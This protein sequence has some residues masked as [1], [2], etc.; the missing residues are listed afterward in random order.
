VQTD[1]DGLKDVRIKNG[2]ASVVQLADPTPADETLAFLPDDACVEEVDWLKLVGSC[3]GFSVLFTEPV[4]IGL[5]DGTEHKGDRLVIGRA[6]PTKGLVDP[7]HRFAVR[8]AGLPELRATGGALQA[9]GL[10]MAP[11]GDA[12]LQAAPGSLTLSDLGDH[13]EAG[14][15][16]DLKQADSFYLDL[17]PI[18]LAGAVPMGASL[19]AQVRGSVDGVPNRSLGE[20]TITKTNEGDTAYAVI[21]DFTDIASPTHTVQVLEYHRL[22]AE[23]TGHTGIAALASSWPRR[24][25]KLDNELECYVGGFPNDTL[26]DLDG[27]LYRG[28]ELRVL[29]ETDGP[30][31]DF[32]SEFNLTAAGLPE[33]TLTR[34]AAGREG[35]CEPGPTRLCLK[36]GRFAVEVDWFTP[37]GLR[38]VGQAFP[39]T[40]DTGTFWFFGE[41]N[42]E[43]V[44]K[45]LDGCSVNGRFWVFA[46]GLTNVETL[47]TV[48][49]TRSGIA[50][51]YLNLQ[52]AAFLPVQDTAAFATCPAGEAAASAGVEPAAT[53]AP[54][55]TPEIEELVGR[56]RTAA[57]DAAGG[58]TA[59]DGTPLMLNG[60]R[61]RVEARWRTARGQTGAGTGVPLTDDSGYIWFFDDDNVEVVVK[62]LDACFVNGRFW[63]FAAGL[64]HVEV[65]LVVTDTATSVART[66]RNPLNTPF[67]PIQDTR[68]FATCE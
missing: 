10:L 5:S 53:A 56:A 57:F 49:D 36:G 12:S 58:G 4:M 26:F 28:D 65:E 30:T 27:V 64:T 35:G 34:A 43:I 39:V 25:G 24:L 54:W 23:L 17:A 33:L 63:V 2:E 19:R 48:T 61:F 62:V 16:I 41:D 20:L 29:A 46:A 55:T 14:V 9:F 47:L 45:V 13:G 21:P 66:Y 1:I 51:T 6:C 60:S 38:G 37:Q 7:L 68:T 8:A 59:T 67:Q 18:E 11:V 50:E 22:V 15:S 31:I 32:K 42:L 52:G 44:V 40:A 3:R